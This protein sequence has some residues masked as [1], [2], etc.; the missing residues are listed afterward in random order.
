MPEA[1]DVA[2]NLKVEMDE[3][4]KGMNLESRSRAVR[5]TNALRNAVLETLRGRGGGKTYRIPFSK[6]TYQ[7]SSPGEVPA[8]RSGNLRKNWRGTSMAQVISDG[9]RVTARITSDMDYAGLLEDG[10]KRMK[11]RPYRE[12]IVEKAQ[13]SIDTIYGK[14]FL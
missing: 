11:P 7:A 13:P 1:A 9:F 10:T 3:I 5:A 4:V 8:V 14:N 12:K 2:K 6:A